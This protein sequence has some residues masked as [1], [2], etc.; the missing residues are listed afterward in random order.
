MLDIPANC[1]LDATGQ[2]AQ[3]A[4]YARLAST[5]ERLRREPDAVVVEFGSAVD[6][7][8]LEQTLA[9]E[10]ECCPFFRF[11]LDHDRRLTVTVADPATL[12]ALDAI[13]HGFRAA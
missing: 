13:E 7:D 2:R 4:R 9:V 6:L 3:R 11:E 10:R 1:S 5:V 8:E 12:P